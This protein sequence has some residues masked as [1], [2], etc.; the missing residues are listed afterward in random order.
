MK[1]CIENEEKELTIHYDYSGLENWAAGTWKTNKE[2]TRN[3]KAFVNESGIKINWVK[4]EAHTGDKWNEYA[5]K[6]AKKALGNEVKAEPELSNKD[7]MIPP[8]EINYNTQPPLNNKLIPEYSVAEIKSFDNKDKNPNAYLIDEAKE[9][10]EKHRYIEAAHL[11]KPYISKDT[12]EILFKT[13]IDIIIFLGDFYAKKAIAYCEAY[14]SEHPKSKVLKS[15]CYALYYGNIRSVV[16]ACE[17]NEKDYLNAKQS[18]GKILKITK[19]SKIINA[20]IY[21]FIE[22]AYR[23]GDKNFVRTVLQIDINLFSKEKVKIGN[24]F[25]QSPFDRINYIIKTLN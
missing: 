8:E 6:L 15:Y 16:S 20:F 25:L 19:N 3:Y 23:I 13:Y 18:V 7:D 11:L 21:P 4:S 22:Y 10:C 12:E 5:D 1:F 17:F 9:L 14:L 2:L 24:V